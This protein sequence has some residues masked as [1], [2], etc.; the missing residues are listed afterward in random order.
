MKVDAI[1][2]RVRALL[3]EIA[4]RS[5]ELES[6]RR[7]PL[8]LVEK[9][10]SA[11]CFRMATPRAFGGAELDIRQRLP[12]LELLSRADAS[13]GWTVAIGHEAPILL[14]RCAASAF[15]S[16]YSRGPDVVLAG[17]AAPTGTADVVAG[18]YRVS[19]RWAWASG[20]LHA[21]F[22]LGNCVVRDGGTPRP[23]R[24]E[25]RPEIRAVV[26]PRDEATVLVTWRTSGLRATGSNDVVIEDVFVPF[27]RSF[28][29]ADAE[30]SLANPVYR[31]FGVQGGLDLAAV[32]LGIAQGA[33]DDV[34]ALARS[35][36]RRLWAPASLAEQPLFQHQLGEA[37]VTLLAARR[38]LHAQ[39]EAFVAD[40]AALPS[41]P[42]M[43]L[44]PLATECRATATWV[45]RTAA[46]V[47][48]AAYQAGGGTSLH[49]SCPLQ[50]RFRDV[51]TLTQHAILGEAMFAQHGAVLA[52]AA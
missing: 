49:E 29:F 17:G 46:R 48:D 33:L 11:G 10:R 26:V 47:V 28:D 2:D 19:G 21:D 5:A 38:T 36:K 4:A 51:H 37:D 16:F 7:I 23:G 22:L 20:S 41:G 3:P 18:G 32:A 24:I 6:L 44:H 9:L 34:T 39:A 50:R 12:I 25:G 45:A 35:G 43:V 40:V 27:E 1:P 8:D 14:S 15:E 13:T 42:A 30:P 52:G 31:A